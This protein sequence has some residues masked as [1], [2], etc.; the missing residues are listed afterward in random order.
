MEGWG[1]GMQKLS[2]GKPTDNEFPL[3]V[4][5]KVLI[6]KELGGS[7]GW[8]P[9]VARGLHAGGVCMRSTLNKGANMAESGRKGLCDYEERVVVYHSGEHKGLLKL[10]YTE[11]NWPHYWLAEF[12]PDEPILYG[13]G[14]GEIC[15]AICTSPE[16]FLVTQYG[17]TEA[18]CMTI[19][20]RLG[21]AARRGLTGR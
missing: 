20:G 21:N 7:R 19:E 1:Y 15:R 14:D 12:V 9:N 18:S 10:T 11:Y 16:P 13:G 3:S 17:V 5:C 4:S 6:I 8:C 2:A